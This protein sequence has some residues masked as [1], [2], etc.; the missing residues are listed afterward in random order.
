[1]RL[2]LTL[3]SVAATKL[4]NPLEL[5]LQEFIEKHPQNPANLL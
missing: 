3:G 2:L 5:P 4:Q 1:M